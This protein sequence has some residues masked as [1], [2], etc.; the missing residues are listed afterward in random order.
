M[1]P[2]TLCNACGLRWAKKARKGDEELGSKG[3]AP[4]GQTD[5]TA[6]GKDFRPER[7]LRPD[8]SFDP[9]AGPWLPFSAGQR[10][11]FGKSLGLLGVKVFISTIVLSMK[12]GSVPAALDS[13]ASKEVLTRR[14]LQ[15]Y[16]RPER[17]DA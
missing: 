2:K 16:L 5:W 9:R 15:N 11:C 17:W 12:L 10:G 1:G 14:P 13:D 4:L 8:G 6:D 3:G 7:W